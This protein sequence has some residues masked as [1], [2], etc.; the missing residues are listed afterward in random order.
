M[1]KKLE[2]PATSIEKTHRQGSQTVKKRWTYRNPEAWNKLEP[3]ATEVVWVVWLRLLHHTCG[4]RFDVKIDKLFSWD[5]DMFDWNKMY[6]ALELLSK[7]GV[8]KIWH[9]G[10]CGL[11]EV[12]ECTSKRLPN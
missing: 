12:L 10:T 5:L 4:G 6:K 1:P 2:G 11:A 3:S 9:D 8:A 7:A